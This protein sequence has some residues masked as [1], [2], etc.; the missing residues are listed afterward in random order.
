MK[1][2]QRQLQLLIYYL[3]IT[4][5]NPMASLTEEARDKGTELL[6]EIIN[7]QSDEIE[8]IK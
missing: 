6:N 7:Q 3:A 5:S 2:T 8:D 1:I 4:S